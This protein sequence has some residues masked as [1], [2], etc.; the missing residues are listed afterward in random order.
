MNRS[1]P[2]KEFPKQFLIDD[3]YVSDTVTIANEFN[4]YFSSIGKTL[5]ES[6]QQPQNR[7]FEEYLPS[8]LHSCFKF[9]PVDSHTVLKV[10]DHLKRKT[11]CGFDGL[12]NKLLKEIKYEILDCLTVIINQSFATNIFPDKMKLA[13]VVPLYKKNENYVFDNYRPIS[14]LP[15]ISK[16]IE[17]IMHAQI[18]DHFNKYNLMFNGQYGFRQNH[19][20]ELAALEVIDQIVCQMDKNE[21]PLNIFLDLSKAFDCI[22]HNILLFKLKYYGFQD[23]SHKL[24]QSY[25]ANRKQYVSFNEVNSDC[26]TID[27]GVPQGSILGPLLFLIYINDI[28][29]SVNF[30]RPVIY[31]DDTTLGTCLSYFGINAVDIES[32]INEELANIHTWL[33]VN[34]LSL[35]L[36]KTKAMV[37]HTKRRAVVLPK[38]CIDQHEVGF[39]D[40]F[41]YLGIILDKHLSWSNHTDMIGNK[42]S[43]LSGI[44]NKLKNFLPQYTLKTF[45]NSLVSAYLNYGILLWGSKC[46]KLEKI[47]KEIVENY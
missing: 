12:S 13:K 40:S 23:S 42:I 30:F 17:K 5:S 18:L 7:S 43:K 39:V 34:K 15:T 21:I 35:N 8:P 33:K 25:L 19:S 22:N 2:K 31:A 46:N 27:V 26:L 9:S 4:R 45:Y 24:I 44:L 20:T 6:V 37:F 41:N 3:T 32:N 47:T 11:S 14:L 16:V 38:I 10:I 1:Q 28:Q 36:N 29:N